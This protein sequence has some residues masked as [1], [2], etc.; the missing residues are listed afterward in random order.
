MR[1]DNFVKQENIGLDNPFALNRNK[2]RLLK[3]GK[4]I[5]RDAEKRRNPNQITQSRLALV[6]FPQTYDGF[7]HPYRIGKRDLSDAFFLA[8]FLQ[9][10]P[11]TCV[12][13]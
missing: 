11:E 13:I 12:H 5:Y 7:A 6:G 9:S 10:F 1:H 8:Q 4:I 3:P 2:Q